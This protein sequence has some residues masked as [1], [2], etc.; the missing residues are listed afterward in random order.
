M[1]DWT[2]E[3]EQDGY[4]WLKTVFRDEPS[5]KIFTID[6]RKKMFLG[7]SIYINIYQKREMFGKLHTHIPWFLVQPTKL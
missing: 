5:F 6:Q 2:V 1:I 3:F 4:Q 7:Y